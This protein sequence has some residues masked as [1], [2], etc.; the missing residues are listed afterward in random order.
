ML[1]NR[2]YE[3]LNLKIFKQK[4]GNNVLLQN[5]S[6]PKPLPKNKIFKEIEFGNFVIKLAEKKSELK[7]AQALR[8]SVFYQEKK[9]K[10]SIP[11]KILGLD[12]DKVDIFADHLIVI[13]K[14]KLLELTD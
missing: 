14:I 11:K 4:E 9:A 7:K 2:I 12:Y 8:Y 5:I 10:P 1:H 6:P 3:K 13:Q